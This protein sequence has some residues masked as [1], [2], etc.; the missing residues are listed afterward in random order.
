MECDDEKCICFCVGGERA[1]ETR[2]RSEVSEEYGNV[3][4]KLTERSLQCCGDELLISSLT[5]RQVDKLAGVLIVILL[6]GGKVFS[7]MKIFFLIKFLIG[8]FRCFLFSPAWL[9]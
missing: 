3:K 6:C 5:R 7:P 2:N 9:E 1:R 8:S 4:I